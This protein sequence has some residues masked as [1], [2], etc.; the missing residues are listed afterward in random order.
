[1]L[2]VLIQPTFTVTIKEKKAYKIHK[3]NGIFLKSGDS[4]KM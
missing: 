3:S 1:M 4:G 2:K